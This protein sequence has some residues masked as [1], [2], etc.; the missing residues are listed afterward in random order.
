MKIIGEETSTNAFLGYKD[1]GR[2]SLYARFVRKFSCGNSDFG[3]EEEKNG[4]E[5]EMRVNPPL[6]PAMDGE[7]RGGGG[8]E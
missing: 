3:R 6:V 1:I 7:I 5:E 2:R 8:S 4:G